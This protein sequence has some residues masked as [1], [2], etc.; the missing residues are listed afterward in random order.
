MSQSWREI[1]TVAAAEVLQ[2]GNATDANISMIKAHG[3]YIG[4][5]ALTGTPQLSK[6]ALVDLFTLY[7]EGKID[8]IKAP[9][10]TQQADGFR[11]SAALGR[12][13]TMREAME[14]DQTISETG[15]FKFRANAEQAAKALVLTDMLVTV[16]EGFFKN[17]HTE[18]IGGICY[19]YKNK[20]PPINFEQGLFKLKVDGNFHRKDLA[21]YGF[22]AGKL[23]RN[24]TND[25]VTHILIPESEVD[26]MLG[27]SKAS[28]KAVVAR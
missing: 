22:D 26:R 25:N 27:I 9:D 28:E 14:G 5:L 18:T 13:A 17:S 11:I 12:A 3:G 10:A 15:I 16:N 7:F 8:T 1:V 2:L 24:S 21:K 23:G 4:T 6:A 20:I 19:P